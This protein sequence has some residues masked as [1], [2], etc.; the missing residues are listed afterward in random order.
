MESGLYKEFDTKQKSK[1]YPLLISVVVLSLCTAVGIGVCF[2]VISSTEQVPIETTKV[3]EEIIIVETPK[4]VAAK[5]QVPIEWKNPIH[6]L[7]EIEERQPVNNA[8]LEEVHEAIRQDENKF[9]NRANNDQVQDLNSPFI[10]SLVELGNNMISEIFN[11]M[12]ESNPFTDIFHDTEG[13]NI[14]SRKKRSIVS[15]VGLNAVKYLNYLSFGKFMFNEVYSITEYAVEGRKLSGDSTAFFLDSGFFFGNNKASQEKKEITEKSDTDVDSTNSIVVNSN[16]IPS[17]FDDGWTPMV[18]QVSLKFI[19]EMLTTL[20]NLMREYLM[21][22]NV[23][24]CLWYMFCKDM[25]HQAKYTDPMGYLARV[26]SVGLQVLVDKENKQRDT[27]NSV[28][29]ALT[30]W[31]PLQCDT[32]FPRCDGPKALEIVNEVANAA[33]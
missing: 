1:F 13:D 22:D 8:I 4:P 11:N 12:P 32:M 23:M 30:H 6:N 7:K 9:S 24:E 27:V 19:T 25:N 18:N 31:Q 15:T 33:R 17:A 5:Q 10:R 3:I 29:R 16:R 20:L 2:Y 14:H 28:W 26:N 21:K